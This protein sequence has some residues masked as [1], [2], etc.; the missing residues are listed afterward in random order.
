MPWPS[1]VIMAL[2]TF[3]NEFKS[4]IK[5]FGIDSEG[6]IWLEVYFWKWV[7]DKVHL[8]KKNR[9]YGSKVHALLWQNILVR[10][11]ITEKSSKM[12]F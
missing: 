11:I 4:L 9:D 7:L 6:K 3:K 10:I 5:G 2:K 12:S 1:K 8:S